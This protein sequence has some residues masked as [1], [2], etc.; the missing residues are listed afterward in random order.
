MSICDKTVD[1]DLVSH[2]NDIKILLERLRSEVRD[3]TR[4]TEAKLLCHDGKIAELC[5]YIKDNLSNSIRELLD[6]MINTR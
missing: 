3:L 1:C 4:N 6:N 5:R 2:P